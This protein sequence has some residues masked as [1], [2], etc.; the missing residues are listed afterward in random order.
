MSRSSKQ[1]PLSS[2]SMQ[3]LSL[4]KVDIEIYQGNSPGDKK[5]AMVGT[6]SVPMLDALKDGSIN[7]KMTLELEENEKK[8]YEVRYNVLLM[9]CTFIF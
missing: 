2:A 5:D 4:V 9:L 8:P 3:L 6:V 1:F 7:S